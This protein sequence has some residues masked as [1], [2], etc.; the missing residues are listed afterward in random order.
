MPLTTPCAQE[1]RGFEARLRP[2]V[3]DAHGYLGDQGVAGQG[4]DPGPDA[5][6]P[7]EPL[8]PARAR[9]EK[10]PVP[11][12]LQDLAEIHPEN[13]AGADHDLVHEGGDL[14]P[15]EGQER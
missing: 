4:V 13:L 3:V 10:E 12:E 8:L 2:E 1:R 7:H 6:L 5:N 14:H 11:R 9:A 15:S